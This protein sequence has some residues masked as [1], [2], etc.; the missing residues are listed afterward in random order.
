[1]VLGQRFDTAARA[2]NLSDMF[3]DTGIFIS[4]SMKMSITVCL[5]SQ[6][7]VNTESRHQCTIKNLC[8]VFYH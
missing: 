5:Y 1:M 6:F 8:P 7:S 4:Y 2:L 3:H